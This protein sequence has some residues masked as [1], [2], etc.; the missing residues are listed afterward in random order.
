MENF[1]ARG[2]KLNDEELKSGRE[3]RNVENIIR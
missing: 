1:V 3:K 2:I